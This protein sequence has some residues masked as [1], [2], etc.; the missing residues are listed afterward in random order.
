MSDNF[1]PADPA[2]FAAALRRFEEENRRDPNLVVVE[3]S[4]Q[5]REL[6]H[7]RWLSEWVLKLEPRASEALRLAARCQHLCR[8]MIPRETYPK[9]RT[10]YLQWREALKTFHAQ[11][12][13][14]I[15]SE[16]GYA[17]EI[18]RRVQ[19][20]NL[21]KRFPQDAETRVLEDALCLV[22]L[23][24]QL[25]ELAGKTSDEKVISALRKSWQKMTPAAQ[26]EALKLSYGPREKALLDRA[27][28]TTT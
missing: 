13:G 1:Q 23:E 8:W 21:K 22:F 16:V 14:E 9:T 6:M 10:G 20:L 26:S 15:L 17:D 24:H 12:A 28:A 11:K 5:P 7:A 19:E 18:I 2:R 3:A 25:A 4:P 27:L